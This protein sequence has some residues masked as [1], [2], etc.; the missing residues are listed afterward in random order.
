[1][2]V[3]WL[4]RSPRKAAPGRDLVADGWRHGLNLAVVLAGIERL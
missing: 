2:F 1:M 3:I 4:S